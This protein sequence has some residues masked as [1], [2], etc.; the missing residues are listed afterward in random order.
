MKKRLNITT[1]NITWWG[2][3]VLEAESDKKEIEKQMAPAWKV[4][5][6]YKMKCV[7]PEEPVATETD[8]FILYENGSKY[9]KFNVLNDL[10]NKEWLKFQK[11][12]FVLNPHPREENVLLHPAKF[13]EELIQE[14]VEFFTKKGGI[15]FDPMVGTGSTLIACASSGRSGIG[16]ELSEKYSLI[17]RD[18]L[19]RIVSQQTLFEDEH[20]YEIFLKI[21]HGDSR[22]MDQMGLP[23][24]DY[25]ITSPPYWDMLLEKGFETQKK[26]KERKLDLNYSDNLS[27]LG[28]IH[29][30]DKFLDELEAVYRKVHV[31]LKP[32]G[33]LTII[34]KNVKKRNRM[35]PLAWDIG[36][37][38]SEFF[39]LKDE[40]I[41]CQNNV[42]LAPYGYGRAW[43]SNTVH[44]YCLNF[45]K[46]T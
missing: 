19:R 21:I 22:D 44:H 38:L 10:N 40:K 35:Y 8:E 32:K 13:P 31:L 39:A 1:I 9:H 43:V 42:K 15:V 29:D 20:V 14:F 37:R 3:M 30:Y 11:S 36:K 23:I 6:D 16:I 45:R 17:A 12:W 28:N 33:Y 5:S 24:V 7:V 2:T 34:L 18:R 4:I 27:D 26:R 46:E 25:C 41:W